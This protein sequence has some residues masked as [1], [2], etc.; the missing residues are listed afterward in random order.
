MAGPIGIPLKPPY[1]K[2]MENR[3]TRFELGRSSEE[4]SQGL[5]DKDD[6]N[7]LA[8]IIQYHG[9]PLVFARQI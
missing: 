5:H 4:I 2:F 1:F 8:L 6:M 9:S 7:L 3:Q